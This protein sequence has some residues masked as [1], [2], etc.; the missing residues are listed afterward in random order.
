MKSFTAFELVR[1]AEVSETVWFKLE[2]SIVENKGRLED[3]ELL[4]TSGGDRLIDNFSRQLAA[5]GARRRSANIVRVNYDL[6]HQM[7]ING[8]NI[9]IVRSDG[10]IYE[11]PFKHLFPLLQGT[12]EQRI[13]LVNLGRGARR[14]EVVAQ[15]EA[16]NVRPAISPEFLA[17]I[18]AQRDKQEQC[19]LVCLGSLWKGAGGIRLTLLAQFG[20][21]WSLDLDFEDKSWSPQTCFPAVCL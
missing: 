10:L 18:Q 8:A 11:S 2:E 20:S 4:A 13:T 9:N 3:L 5:V 6:S 15:M 16:L 21:W 17:Y 7:Q 14:N 19:D 12:V 1:R